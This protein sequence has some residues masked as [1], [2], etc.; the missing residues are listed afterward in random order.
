MIEDEKGDG[1]VETGVSTGAD[2]D[3]TPN[4]TSGDDSPTGVTISYTPI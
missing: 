2:L 1:V 3:Q 4:V